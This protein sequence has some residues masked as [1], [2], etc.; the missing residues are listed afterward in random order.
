MCRSRTATGTATVFS[1]PGVHR[2]SWVRGSYWMGRTYS[3]PSASTEGHGEEELMDGRKGWVDEMRRTMWRHHLAT[4]PRSVYV[5]EHLTWLSALIEKMKNNVDD[6][7]DESYLNLNIL[8]IGFFFSIN[9][10]F[11]GHLILKLKLQESSW[12]F[13]S[14]GFC[15]PS[16]HPSASSSSSSSQND[17]H[18]RL[19][20]DSISA[21]CPTQSTRPPPMGFFLDDFYL[22]HELWIDRLMNIEH[23][24]INIDDIVFQSFVVVSVVVAILFVLVVDVNAV[25]LLNVIQ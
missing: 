8:L 3:A 13:Q 21:S 1:A 17:L 12:S 5:H 18:L 11:Y 2:P 15:F 19:K 20:L 23:I 7:D 10:P 16:I 4:A 24:F 25:A 14:R 9:F 22:H 6:D